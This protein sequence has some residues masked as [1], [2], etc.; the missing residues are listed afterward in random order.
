MP[1]NGVSKLKIDELNDIKIPLI[2]VSEYNID[3]SE[4]II[5]IIKICLITIISFS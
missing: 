1:I 4:F 5:D 2:I 3:N